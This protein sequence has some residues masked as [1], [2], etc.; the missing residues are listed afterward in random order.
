MKQKQE[1]FHTMNLMVF[2][3]LLSYGFKLIGYTKIIRADGKI[4]NDFWF[5]GSCENCEFSAEKVA[6]YATTGTEELRK[7]SPDHPIL[8]MKNALLY[9]NDGV[10]IIKN[11][12]PL[13][14]IRKGE[15]TALVPAS[16]SEETKRK[17]SEML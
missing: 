12:E 14:E 7:K 16:A 10:G 3:M 2:S 17:I 9:R 4:S 15:R 5:E 6:Y 1:L 13:V 11:A 8:W